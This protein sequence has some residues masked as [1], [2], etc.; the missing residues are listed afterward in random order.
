MQLTR[1]IATADGGS[2]FEEVELAL[3]H[4]RVHDEKSDPM[5]A[6]HV[7]FRWTPGDMDF[8][9]HPAPRRRLVIVM[10]GALEITTTDGAVRI[11]RPGDLLEVTDTTGRGHRSRALS[12]EG[13]RSAF[14]ALDDDLVTNR[15][16]ELPAPAPGPQLTRCYSADGRSHFADER[17]DYLYGGPSGMVTREIPI[18][19]WQAVKKPGSLNHDFH[20]APQRQIVL[21]LTGGMEVDCGDGEVRRILPGEVYQGEDLHGRGHISRAIDGAERICVFAWL[22]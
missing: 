2:T 21:M 13:F 22:A 20:P 9:F 6:R 4:A 19:A 14:I 18:T 10:T 8:D 7:S 1:T 17:L 15:L 3:P 12:A 16:S 11:F 5:P